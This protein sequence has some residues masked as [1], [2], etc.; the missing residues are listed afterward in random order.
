MS[1][2]IISR[3]GI[4]KKLNLNLHSETII[5][6]T[7]WKVPA[8]VWGSML[9]VRIFGGGGGAG[10]LTWSSFGP[11]SFYG[12]GGGGGGWMNN[13]EI[14][15]SPETQ[16]QITI[17][18]GGKFNSNG[19]T[20]AFG[21][22][23]SA[24]GGARGAIFKGSGSGEGGD[25]G[26]GG[27]GAL[28]IGPEAYDY[29]KIYA[30]CGYGEIGYQFGGGGGYGGNGGPWGGGGGGSGEFIKLANGSY[31]LNR[32]TGV[33]TDVGYYN[34]G[35]TLVSTGV[36]GN[37]GIYGGNGSNVARGDGN[38]TTINSE[39]GINTIG[40]DT[41]PSNYQGAGAR[42]IESSWYNH[43]LVSRYRDTWY[44][45]RCGGG[46]GGYGGNGGRGLDSI[47]W[48]NDIRYNGYYSF[49]QIE[50]DLT[51][52]FGAITSSGGGG[53]YGS[54]GGNSN[55]GAGG[56]GGG[57]GGDGGD[58]ARNYGG[59]GGGYGQGGGSKG[60]AGYGGGGG[61]GYPNGGSGICIIQYYVNED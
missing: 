58:A 53:G 17:G 30:G 52:E 56:G 5:T 15:V 47:L 37:G 49:R 48:L 43:H 8:N 24:N 16:I 51:I 44:N 33:R 57:Y 18:D 26:S 10:N 46:G 34:R 41:V 39:A 21:T 12:T 6:N 59:G 40:N 31:T 22:Y 11:N 3:R 20:S 45:V 28:T 50:Y 36:G 42:G 60:A 54:N 13:G 38:T 1:E 7:N 32:N 4:A 27:G 14:E 9:N 55:Y 61:G 2:A 29:D 35:S 19:G 23:L 25:G